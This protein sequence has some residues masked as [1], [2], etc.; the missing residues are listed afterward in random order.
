MSP[1]L[2]STR[3]KELGAYGILDKT[4]VQKQPEIYEY[5]LTPAG[6]ELGA[7]VEAMGIWGHRWVESKPGLE[8]LDPGLLMWDMRRNLN[9][10]PLP[11]RRINIQFTY[12]ELGDGEQNWW[13]QITGSIS[14]RWIPALTSIFLRAAICGR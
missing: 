7:V 1:A 10:S 8:N 3:L 13:I 6:Q 11:S 5:R 9:V 14:V 4:L 12:S 2:L